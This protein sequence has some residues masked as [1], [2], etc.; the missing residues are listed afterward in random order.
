MVVVSLW[1]TVPCISYDDQNRPDDIK[2]KNRS[3]VTMCIRFGRCLGREMGSGAISV[4][5]IIYISGMY[6]TLMY[7][8]WEWG[9]SFSPLGSLE[10]PM[11]SKAGVLVLAQSQ[12]RRLVWPS[13]HSNAHGLLPH[14]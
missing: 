3:A 2:S 5:Y 14:S 6:I 11:V 9:L 12:Q 8:G 4:Y 10:A 13:T 1:S 7:Y